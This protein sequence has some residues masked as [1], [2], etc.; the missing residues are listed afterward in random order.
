MTIPGIVTPSVP[1][2]VSVGMALIRG[3]HLSRSRWKPTVP[4][5][6]WAV[7]DL[8]EQSR[9]CNDIVPCTCRRLAI[10]RAPNRRWRLRRTAARA[11]FALGEEGCVIDTQTGQRLGPSIRHPLLHRAQFSPD[12]E[13]L[14]TATLGSP[15]REEPIVRIWDVHRQQSLSTRRPISSTGCASAPTAAAWPSHVSA[16][17]RF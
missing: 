16:K 1:T 15:R 17:P 8:L 11:F 2:K 12:G 14:A 7:K 9:Q 3:R 6:G 5:R 10:L 13:Y 4:V